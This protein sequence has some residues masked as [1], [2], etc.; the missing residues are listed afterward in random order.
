MTRFCLILQLIMMTLNLTGCGVAPSTHSSASKALSAT[1]TE[2]AS[3]ELFYWDNKNL[4]FGHVAVKIAAAPMIGDDI[5]VS[6]A[7][8]NDFA[9][10]LQKHGKAPERLT[11]PPPSPETLE[12]FMSWYFNSTYAD[13][14]S[15]T[16][17]QDYNI[18]RHNCA[19]AALNVLRQLG[20]A[21]PI[22][23]DHPLALRPN[24][25]FR[26]ASAISALDTSTAVA[27]LVN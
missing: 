7:M 23:G 2:S 4:G 18:L 15:D 21:L 22:N 17:G 25:V 8:G 26:A 1:S 13:P 20:Y 3:V 14:Y 12:H 11:L 5:Y 10:D 16:Y 6:Y 9:V 27:P 24:Q 19:H